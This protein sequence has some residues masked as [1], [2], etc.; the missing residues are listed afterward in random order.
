MANI[1]FSRRGSYYQDG[2]SVHCICGPEGNLFGEVKKL[3]EDKL[4]TFQ[5]RG[6]DGEYSRLATLLETLHPGGDPW[7]PLALRLLRD[8][9]GRSIYYLEHVSNYPDGSAE[10]QIYDIVNNIVGQILPVPMGPEKS[11]P[12]VGV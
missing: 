11:G 5:L 12:T 8:D 1:R 6:D 7:K 9:G 3:S 4:D 10:S 2:W